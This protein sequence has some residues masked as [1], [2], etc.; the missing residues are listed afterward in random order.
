MQVKGT[1]LL[2]FIIA[3]CSKGRHFSKKGVKEPQMR[4]M[5]LEDLIEAENPMNLRAFSG[6][7]NTNYVK[8]GCFKENKKNPALPQE[9]FQ[10]MKPEEPNYSGQKVDWS[11]YD[12]YIKGLACRCAEKSQAKGYTYFGLQ[13][14]ARCFSGAH[15]SST[16]KSHGP[17][18]QC[19]NKHYTSCD[20]N[21]W[22][23]CVGKTMEDNYVYEIKEASSGDGQIDYGKAYGDET[24][25]ETK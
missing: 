1:C 6:I 20:D 18:I 14:Y 4:E 23:Q 3:T 16:Y 17:S 10:D 8:V 15:A 7:C 13:D 24:S 2:L 5:S 9:L 19:S 11:D 12:S 22:G 25:H 21:A